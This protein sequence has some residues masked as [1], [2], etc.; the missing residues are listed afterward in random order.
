MAGA[1]VVPR[2]SPGWV[3]QQRARCGLISRTRRAQFRPCHLEQPAL[4]SA[5]DWIEANR[6][7]WTERL[8][9]LDEHLRAIQRPPAAEKTPDKHL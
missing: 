8:D 4:D 2:R 5:V 9:R 7:I 6:R 3:W 1:T